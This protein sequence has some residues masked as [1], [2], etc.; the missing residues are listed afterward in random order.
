MERLINY[1]KENNIK[2]EKDTYGLGV[3]TIRKYKRYIRIRKDE[4]ITGSCKYEYM[5]NYSFPRS[6]HSNFEHL[7]NTVIRI[8]LENKPTDE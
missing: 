4:K 6:Y 7:T 3:V 1:L 2:Y 5:F 8:F